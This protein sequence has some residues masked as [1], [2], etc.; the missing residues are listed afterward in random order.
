[1]TNLKKIYKKSK[2]IV[3]REIEGEM[4]LI[5][6]ASD[7][8]DLENDLIF[9]LNEIGKEIWQKIDGRKKVLD[10][11]RELEDIYDIEEGELT[12]DVLNFLEELVKKDILLDV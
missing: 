12:R 3:E 2:D 4:I 8:V 9:S 5:P 10:I 6:I 11:V 1:M 7:V